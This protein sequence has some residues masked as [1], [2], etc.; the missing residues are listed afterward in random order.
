MVNRYLEHAEIRLRSRQ[1][2]T[3]NNE[4][5]LESDWIKPKKET[6][7]RLF[8]IEVLRR[9]DRHRHQHRRPSIAHPSSAILSHVKNRWWLKLFKSRL[10]SQETCL[11]FQSG[12]G[13]SRFH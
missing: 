8:Q 12:T 10:P 13:G 7:P 2:L 11:S 9:D 1:V 5:L 6:V 4:K 3:R